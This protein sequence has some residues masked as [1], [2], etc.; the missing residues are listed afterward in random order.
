MGAWKGR[1]G[2]AL[3]TA[4]LVSVLASGG[5]AT[6]NK[7]AGIKYSYD[8][9]A[10]FSERKTY[11]WAPSFSSYMYRKDPLLEA[12]VQALADQLLAQKGYNRTSEKP[13]L[14]ISISYDF[15]IAS[16]DDIYRVRTLNLNIYKVDGNNLVW[17]GTAVGT[18]NTDA[19]SGE[20]TQTVREILS[21]FPPN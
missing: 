7:D 3:I 19:A 13:D 10:S 21:N 18:I 8:A 4:V 17:R 9:K 16:S 5:C 12:N 15:D 1:R 20:L 2:S 11:A 14:T 6:Y